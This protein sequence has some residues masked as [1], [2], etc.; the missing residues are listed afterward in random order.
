MRQILVLVVLV[1]LMQAAVKYGVSNTIGVFDPL[2]LVTTGF[3]LIGAYT[4]GELFRRMRLPALLGYLCAG[5]L[6]G[7]KLSVILFGDGGVAPIGSGVI[8]ELGLVNLLAVGVIGTMGGGE[9]K[10]AELRE[11][12]PKIAAICVAVFVLVLP[13]VAGLVLALTFFA[14][15]LV[16]FLSELPLAARIA[17]AL[18]FG[19]L[20]VG[21]SPSAT[22]ALL[23]EVRAHGRFTSFVLGVVVFADLVLV[24]T[25]LLVL[26]LAKL[27]I[28]PE[29]VSVARVAEE[30]PHI[31]AE[32][33]WALAIGV[34]V[35]AIYILYLRFVRREVLLFS[36]VVVFVTSFI[37]ARLHAET[38]LA[39]LV[40]GFVVQ[41]FSRHGH[42][43]I[44]AFERISL[45]VF[46]IYFTSQA[47]ALDLISVTKYLPLTLMLVAVRVGLFWWG[48][49]VAARRVGV[50]D[51]LRGHLQVSFLSQGGVD[52]VLAGIIAD[53]IPGWG[54]EVQTVTVATILFYI[55]G[56]PPFLARALDAMGESE[57]ARERGTEDLES[58][59]SSR[60]GTSHAGRDPSER[61]LAQPHSQDPILDAR[62]AELH[63]TVSRLRDEL[64]DGQILG[65]ARQRRYI[66]TQLAQTVAHSLDVDQ[67]KGTD[68]LPGSV[69]SCLAELDAGIA[70]VGGQQSHA[71][72]QPFDGRTLTRLFGELEAAQRFGESYRVA[73]TEDLFE[74]R[75]GRWTQLLRWARRVRR[76]IAGPGMRTVPIGRL[77]R[78]HVTLEVPV[79]LW[80]TARTAEAEIWHALLDHYRITHRHLEALRDGTWASI[81]V[82]PPG[83]PASHAPAHAAPEHAE[84]QPL[85]ASEWLEMA[86]AR[87]SE[88][89]VEICERLAVL[90]DQLEDG[91][92]LALARAW[93]AFLDSV[94]LAGTLERPAWRHRP[95]TRY[96]I[97]RAATAELLER[98]TADR[99][100]AAGRFDALV[101]LANAQHLARVI[102]TSASEF[103]E[104]FGAALTELSEDFEQARVH[105][106]ELSEPDDPAQ[107]DARVQHSLALRQSLV[108]MSSHVER[109][110]RHVSALAQREPRAVQ[111]MLLACPEQL[112]PSSEIADDGDSVAGDAR[113]T[114]IRLRAWLSQTIVS[115]F[116]VTRSAAEQ[117][118]GNG[119]AN[120]RQ[121]LG[122]VA[123][124][125]DYHLGPEARTSEARIDASLGE[126]ILGL[127]DRA[128]GQVEELGRGTRVHVDEKVAAAERASLGPIV[129]H[130]WEEIRRRLRRLDDSPRVPVLDLLRERRQTA[131]ARMVAWTRR[132]ADEL[133]ALFAA[134]PTASALASWRA[135]LFG[136]RSSMPEPYQRLFTSVPAETVGLLIG[137]SE[138]GQ[139]TEQVDRG[140]SG[141]GSPV[142]VYGE[143]GSGKR[144]LVRQLI[145]S[146]NNRVEIRWLRLSPSLDCEADV[147]R[148]L[149]GWFGLPIDSQPADFTTLSRQMQALTP[150]R[151]RR[152]ELRIDDVDGI[153][154][155]SQMI[156]ER[157]MLVVVENSERL[158]RR[159]HDGLDCMR[160]FLEFVTATGDHVQWVVLMAEPA[161][162]VLD[163]ALE[164]RARFPAPL[165]VP[166]MS[167]SQLAQVLDCRHR[168]SG[169]ALRLEPGAPSLAG[170]L[171]GPSA[172]WRQWRRYEDA[173]FERLAQ[174][175]GG[176]VRQALRLWLAAARADPRD[177]AGVIVGPLPA[178]I[179][180]LLDELPLSS[181]VLLA[182]LMLHGPLPPADLHEIYGHRS[183]DHDAELA[184]LAHLGLVVFDRSHSGVEVVVSVET[185]LVQPLTMELRACNLL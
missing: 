143:R 97:A 52:L 60:T 124:V 127:L 165:W 148:E 43:L 22:L 136:P 147:V 131:L 39:F 106:R 37:C 68:E 144:T 168:L 33:G 17:G 117:E 118:L 128:Q 99:E 184:R 72:F 142:L 15:Q 56:G 172:A 121:A 59:V 8:S 6:F 93:A 98:S 58:R 137:R 1:A 156:E 69:A 154:G 51:T 27:A 176:N 35:G 9:I 64:I 41:N 5:M 7:P 96:D 151:W 174:L 183:L 129:A 78:F 145:F 12:F 122:H 100:R 70:A 134:R 153:P 62:L 82:A 111:E 141:T 87:A 157:R 126:R 112:E 19:T 11:N 83:E 113:R 177:S 171:R 85:R 130:R 139:L 163:A 13:A 169:Y 61:K 55:V 180:P 159:T 49:G 110:R 125:V 115:D 63:A 101:A 18:L 45:P 34:V 135:V 149:R 152:A 173:M 114:P 158:F 67:S 170:W 167:A 155:N 81:S 178:D 42:T 160:R 116:D 50:D 65:R 162:H 74:L 103:E 46:V 36:L 73:R 140:L 57:A 20:A 94:E 175:S 133:S 16:P 66:V 80:G 89:C 24:A 4:M 84:P 2:T 28:S 181:R 25:F 146:L 95:S 31:A 108:R 86:R 179:C 105:C 107:P 76:A 90:D 109:L 32:F 75:G 185:R 182:A 123:Q 21:M 119:L 150:V 104:R 132:F 138:L 38:L 88:R 161:V 47:A 53:S 40:A 10:L 3:I 29:G 92:P 164:L 79:A 102:R 26:A 54:V 166:P 30:L 23:Q 91:L 48:I 14:P 44:E 77:W 71:R 120:L